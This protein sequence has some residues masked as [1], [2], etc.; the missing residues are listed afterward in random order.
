MKLDA[1]GNP[2]V[3]QSVTQDDVTQTDENKKEPSK[4]EQ[5]VSQIFEKQMSAFYEKLKSE[6]KTVTPHVEN[7]TVTQTVTPTITSQ[8][9]NKQIDIEAKITE[10]EK[11]L[12]QKY[13]KQLYLTSLSQTQKEYLSDIEGYESFTINQMKKILSKISLPSVTVTNDDAKGETLE[14]IMKKL[15]PKK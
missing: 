3:E 12:E 4:F 2:I 13:E 5:M 8:N 14:D 11:R 6:T 9:D 1:N 10:M 7:K 15:R